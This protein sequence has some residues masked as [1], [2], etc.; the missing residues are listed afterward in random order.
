M[1]ERFKDVKVKIVDREFLEHVPIENLN[2]YLLKNNWYVYEEIY[3]GTKLTGHRWHKKDIYF[4]IGIP[5]LQ[6]YS[7]Y[8]QRLTEALDVLSEIENK[9]QLQIIEEIYNIEV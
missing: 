4:M 8:P 5:L 1:F 7:D 3:R 6:S 2:K 9:N